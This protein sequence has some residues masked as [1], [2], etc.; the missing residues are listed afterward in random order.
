MKENLHL[1]SEVENY[2]IA[3]GSDLFASVSKYR[4][5]KAAETKLIKLREITTNVLKGFGRCNL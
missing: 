4:M 5:F 3:K 2:F 1:S